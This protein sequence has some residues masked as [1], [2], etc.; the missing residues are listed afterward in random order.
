MNRRTFISALAASGTIG[1]ARL[2]RAETTA[3]MKAQ[4]S[5][6]IRAEVRRSLLLI[7][8]EVVNPLPWDLYLSTRKV[9]V[10]NRVD[11]TPGVELDPQART[12]SVYKLP[13]IAEGADFAQPIQRF[14]APVRAGKRFEDIIQVALPA[15]EFRHGAAAVEACRERPG[16]YRGLDFAIQYDAG[17]A[18]EEAVWFGGVQVLQPI[19]S[20]SLVYAGGW[21]K[22]PVI[23]LDIP[24]VECGPN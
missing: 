11:E 13:R 4:A 3:S 18:R 12:I 14:F 1:K 15:R 17:D 9:V 19:F 22:S 10:N 16:R 24:V 23:P 5:L 21:L 2:A 20:P 6:R 8:Y 7:R